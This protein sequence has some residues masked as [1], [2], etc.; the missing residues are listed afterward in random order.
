MANYL[1]LDSTLAV[2]AQ[3]AGSLVSIYWGLAM[4]GRFIGAGIM[5][6]ANP[7]LVLTL[8]ACAAF[9]MTT[10]SSLSAGMVA[11]VTILSVGLF[12]S[13]MFPTIFALAVEGMGDRTPQGSGII[14][15]AIVGGAIVPLTTGVAA[16]HAGLHFAL[17]IPAVCYIW[18]AFYGIFAARHGVQHD[19]RPAARV[20]MLSG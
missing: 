2:A 7:A 18:I 10:T 19:V 13:I 9:V 20:P 12:N 17:L 1:M 15:L 5:R 8:C 14:C 6:K 4:V 3:M 11:A 16:D